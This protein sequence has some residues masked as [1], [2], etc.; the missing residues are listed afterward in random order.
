MLEASKIIY[1]NNDWLTFILA[2][3][4]IVLVLVKVLFNEKLLD[5]NT[6]FF[7][8]KYL[9][10]YYNKEKN[11]VFNLF[12]LLLFAI[13]FLVISIIIY[14]GF[15]F[16][17]QSILGYKSVYL[18]ISILIII[19]IYFGF[20]FLSNFFLASI[21]NLQKVQN[22]LHYEKNSYL[23]NLVLWILPLLIFCIYLNSFQVIFFK[24][25]FTLFIVLLCARYFLFIANNKKLFFN[26]IFYFI[27]YLCALE[28]APLII[29]FKLTI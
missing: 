19:L 14:L 27:L 16:F 10:I 17:E 2:F 11:S 21:F 23:N 12:Q 24:I 22:K 25:T 20:K 4:L 1:E 6:L 29:I 15:D 5:T 18:F 13:Q 28:I 7:S 8:K 9:L 26:H 3:I